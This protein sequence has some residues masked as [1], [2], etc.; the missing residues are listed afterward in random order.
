MKNRKCNVFFI[1]AVCTV[2]AL[3]GINGRHIKA[4]E[5]PMT[6]ESTSSSVEKNN[7]YSFTVKIN[8]KLMDD[9]MRLTIPTAITFDAEKIVQLNEGKIVGIEES[10]GSKEI[11]LNRELNYPLDLTFQMTPTNTGTQEIS[12]SETDSIKETFTFDVIEEKVKTDAKANNVILNATGKDYPTIEELPFEA[13]NEEGEL[14]GFTRMTQNN[15]VEFPTNLKDG[16]QYYMSFG[17]IS[18]NRANADIRPGGSSGAYGDTLYINLPAVGANTT[19]IKNISGNSNFYS[20]GVPLLGN[21]V[22]VK[23]S[24]TLSKW[25][26][27][28]YNNGMYMGEAA[29]TYSIATDKPANQTGSYYPTIVK[30]YTNGKKVISY[31]VSFNSSSLSATAKILGYY[32]VVIEPVSKTGRIKTTITYLNAEGVSRNTAMAYGLH[33]DIQG[34][35]TSSKLFSLGDNKGMYF[36]EDSISDGNPY[37]LK[38]YLGDEPNSPVAQFAHN[39]YDDAVWEKVGKS[40]TSITS[41]AEIGKDAQYKL[42]HP[43]VGFR[44]ANKLL[45]P[46][47]KGEFS[48]G[49]SVTSKVDVTAELTKEAQNIT[50]GAIKDTSIDDV[51]EYSVSLSNDQ[52]INKGLLED[53]LP[54]E[55]SEPYDLVLYSYPDGTASS[56]IKTPLDSSQ[57]YNKDTHKISVKQETFSPKKSILKYKVNV[58][59]SAS[60]KTI[61]NNV[62]I[63][64]LDSDEEP[65]DEEETS[66]DVTVKKTPIVTISYL[67]ELGESIAT[68][69]VLK[70]KIGE[71]YQE[72]AIE[73]D[74][75]QYERVVG[76]PNGKFTETPQTVQFIYK[77]NRFNLAQTVSRLDGSLADEVSLGETLI[78]SVEVKSELKE[79]N[80]IVYYKEFTLTEPLD[81][82]LGVPDNL[83]LVTSDGTS[84]GTVVYDPTTHTI[85]GKITESD[86]L[87][88]T[89][90]FFLIYQ[91][92]VKEGLPNG[93]LIREKATAEGNYTNGMIARK[94]ESNEVTSKV[95]VGDLIFESAPTQLNFGDPVKIS[96]KEEKY[97]LNK[98]SGEL[99][100]KDLRGFGKEWSMT[101]KMKEPLIH[102]SGSKL[103]DALYYQ[104]NGREQVIGENQSALIHNEKTTSANSVII[105]N[106]WT[107]S[108]NQPFIKTRAGE[109]KRGEYKGIIQ[110]TL[111]DVPT[112]GLP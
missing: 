17:P 44:W 99:S 34:K 98:R 10:E 96:Q 112:N 63:N 15:P 90:S 25:A 73:I 3:L 100:V 53:S 11:T 111:Q 20:S 110:W 16:R 64:G 40:F 6:I 39:N 70:G 108:S 29:S 42:S 47:E 37:L 76:N 62:T 83:Q 91:A 27:Y 75:Y 61:T 77:E 12:I 71:S 72:T 81:S 86:Q 51:L 31:G 60:G 87:N 28:A 82:S 88:R 1:V 101:A 55:V 30:M 49:Q 65:I 103:T 104:I 52:V 54:K 67:N 50:T 109:T 69:K 4:D 18:N 22:A 79:A 5:S 2:L 33:V 78:Y 19:T 85:T 105:T 45:N 95:I 66:Y 94:K 13:L 36:K 9:R 84:V 41:P 38:F 8:S 32:K 58:L 26:T 74:G 46:L 14:D 56:E 68:D 107:D 21:Q 48:L 80:P 89:N 92:T 57:V 7:L 59:P 93:T 106:T 35:H 102:S 97:L 43:A 24:G 23:P